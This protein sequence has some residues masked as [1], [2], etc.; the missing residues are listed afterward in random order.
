MLEKIKK[1]FLNKHFLTFACLFFI[2][3]VFFGLNLKNDFLS[4]DWDFLYWAK[5]NQKNILTYFGTNYLGSHDGGSFR[6]LLNVFWLSFYNFFGLN[7]L[8]Y[9]LASLFLHI[10]NAGLLYFLVLKINFFKNFKQKNLLAILSAILFLIMPNKSEA[11]VWT[12][13]IGDLLA[14]FFFLLSLLFLFFAEE[15]EKVKKVLFFF[16]SLFFFLLSLFSKE[17]AICLPLIVFLYF[18][19]SFLLDEN[20]NLKKI[21]I[22]LFKTMLYFFVLFLFFYWRFKAIGL[23]LADYREENTETISLFSLFNSQI[24]FLTAMFF[25]GIWRVKITL[26]IMQYKILFLLVF[27]F[28]AFFSYF[29]DK[30]IFLINLFLFLIYLF[31]TI[32]ISRFLLDLNLNY[33]SEEGSRWLYLPSLFFVILFLFIVLS[34]FSQ[35]S[36]KN[37]FYFLIV[38]FLFFAFLGKELIINNLNW[39]KATKISQ[40]II[41][42]SEKILLTEKYDGVVLSGLPDNYHGA[43]IFRNNF[44]EALE[45]KTN[46]KPDMIVV[47]FRTLFDLKN[48]FAVE[49]IQKDRII[50]LEEKGSKNIIADK[51][52][53]SVDYNFKLVSPLKNKYAVSYLYSDDKMEIKFSEDFLQANKNKKILFLFFDGNQIENY[54]DF[55]AIYE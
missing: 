9:H 51:D 36:K 26:F 15:K 53:Y 22:I 46:L 21:L 29:K 54:P 28:F 24:S 2:A 48:K 55:F 39:Q 19:Y 3:F 7:S 40:N 30:K 5:N 45:L 31:S 14:T 47:K 25:T 37:Q 41:L 50:F 52:F 42:N 35:F 34:I 10:V 23:F 11:V 18:I 32:A 20:K 8:F 43:Y 49:K 33:L 27:L 4:D 17:M 6:P 16:F 44:K 1:F 12:A 13:A 38:L